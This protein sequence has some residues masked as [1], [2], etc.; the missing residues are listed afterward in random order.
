MRYLE[1]YKLARDFY[2]SDRVLKANLQLSR[3]LRLKGGALKEKG[4]DVIDLAGYL[5]E[6]P[7]GEVES[8]I[9]AIRAAVQD[10]LKDGWP[11]PDLRGIRGLRTAIS[12]M[13]LRDLD[14][15][16]DPESEILVTGG[17]SMQAIYN[18]MQAT[19]NPGD[20]VIIFSPG[21]TYDEHIQLAG[22]RPVFVQLKEEE[23]FRFDMEDVERAITAK[24]RMLVVNSPHNPT[25]HVAERNELDSLADIAKKH[26]LLVLSDEVL[27][28]WVYDDYRHVSIASL[29]DMRERTI[30]VSSVTKNGMFDW[31]VGWSIAN[32]AIVRQVEKIAFWQNEF[33]PPLLQIG[34]EGHLRGFSEWIPAVRK[35]MEEKMDLIYSGLAKIEQ[36]LCFRPQGGLT[37]FPNIRNVCRSS[38]TFAN[39]LLDAESVLVAPGIAY[40]G[41]SHVRVGYSPSKEQITEAIERIER[42]IESRVKEH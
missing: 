1:P 10:A 25:G 18:I 7:Y 4:A 8:H 42:F 32:E 19:I 16:V 20:E 38:M 29:S 9:D 30:I 39:D 26:D 5:I 36:I 34:A 28:K 41:E 11:R 15:E 37:V 14:I 17:G 27:W 3:D 24:T 23:G 12:E 40:L 33:A 6:S 22:G 35:V 2:F 21:L 13:A 31:R